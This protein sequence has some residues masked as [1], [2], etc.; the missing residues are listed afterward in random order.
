MKPG[1]YRIIGDLPASGD[2]AAPTPTL[3]AVQALVDRR[4]PAGTRLFDPIW[5]SGFRINGRKVTAYRH[6]RTFLAGDAAHVHSPARGQGMNTGMQDALNLAWKLALVLRGEATEGLLDS[7][8]PERS[9]VGDEVLKAAERLTS[10]A[11]LRNPVA[12]ALGNLA[13]HLALGLPRFTQGV[14]KT[15]SEVEVHYADS[16]LNGPHVRGLRSGDRVAPEAT[17]VP[18]GAGDAPRFALY[19]AES[20]AAARLAVIYSGLVEAEVRPP[21]ATDTL[22][23]VRPDGYLAC[24]ATSAEHLAPYLDRL[25]PAGRA[26]A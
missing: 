4:G 24:S 12:Q 10:V 9:A 7:Y 14:A 20:P 22:A 19:A 6:G 25:T 11:T 5:L 26:A 8:S 15:M 18:V 23:L 13:G 17:A 3:D 21:L 2:A 1:R 16:L